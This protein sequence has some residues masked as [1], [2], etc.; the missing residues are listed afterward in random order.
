MIK[1]SGIGKQC[2]T[3]FESAVDEIATVLC[4]MILCNEE[5]MEPRLKRNCI[6]LLFPIIKLENIIEE[7]PL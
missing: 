1:L 7:N 5:F 2:P 6:S 4:H 3:F